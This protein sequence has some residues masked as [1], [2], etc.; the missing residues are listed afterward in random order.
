M[1]QPLV[2]VSEHGFLEVVFVRQEVRQTCQCLGVWMQKG[3]TTGCGKVQATLRAKD[4][5]AASFAAFPDAA[6]I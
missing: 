1:T 3:S 4:D 2:V 5:F 6:V